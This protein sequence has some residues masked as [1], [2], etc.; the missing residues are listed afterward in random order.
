MQVFIFGDSIAF[1]QWDKESGWV[2][3]LKNYLSDK[4]ISSSQENYFEVHN[5]GVPGD[6]TQDLLERFEKE[7]QARYDEEE[8]TMFIFAIG[9]NDSCI[10]LKEN[11]N[12]VDKK[13]FLENLDKLYKIAN[14]HASKILY[15]GLTPVEEEK[16][17]PWG[18]L[19]QKAFLNKEIVEYNRILEEFV[20]KNSLPFV[21]ILE[22]F[23]VDCK[24]CLE[25]G[26]H[27]NSQGHE[28]IFEHVK[29]TME[30]EQLKSN[31]N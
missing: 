25:D 20:K 19:R 24:D 9:I 21:P 11:K 10:L 13:D 4:S 23:K 28:F 26:L 12:R 31:V 7:Y 16:T 14:M 30:K 17:N 18:L 29:N 22:K 2:E 15:V 6:T 3:R 27:P 1:G 8:E 5:L